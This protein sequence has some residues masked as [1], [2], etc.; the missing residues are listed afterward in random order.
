MFLGPEDFRKRIL[1]VLDVV[2]EQLRIHDKVGA[3]QKQRRA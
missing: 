3:R 1:A 2:E